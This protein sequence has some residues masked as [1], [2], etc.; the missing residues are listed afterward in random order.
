VSVIEKF[1]RWYAAVNVAAAAVAAIL[2][3][4]WP[5]ACGLAAAGLALVQWPLSRRLARLRA[6][7]DEGW[8][9][10]RGESG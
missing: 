6:A 8:T 10:R 5:A 9:K 7:L 2:G 3:A 1:W 4:W